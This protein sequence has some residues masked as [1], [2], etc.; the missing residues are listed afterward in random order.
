MMINGNQMSISRLNYMTQRQSRDSLV[1][2][3]SPPS[4][5]STMTSQV[6]LVSIT[7]QS[8]L[9]Q[10]IRRQGSRLLDRMVVME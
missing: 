6:L 2:I 9:E 3:L 4:P 5:L 10:R 7:E 1:K 8:K